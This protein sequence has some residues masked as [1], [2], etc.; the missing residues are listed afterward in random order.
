MAGAADKVPDKAPATA[1]QQQV[2]PLSS[3][4]LD[5]VMASG[6]GGSGGG[7]QA[8]GGGNGP[9]QVGGPIVLAKGSAATF[10]LRVRKGKAQIFMADTAQAVFWNGTAL[11]NQS[12]VQLES[13]GWSD[14]GDVDKNT[15]TRYYLN[16]HLKM[17]WTRTLEKHSVKETIDGEE[18]TVERL[19]VAD[20]FEAFDSKEYKVTE[21]QSPSQAKD[22]W[23]AKEAT[24]GGGL[25]ASPF[26]RWRRLAAMKHEENETA[27]LEAEVNH[28]V[29]L[30]GI[31]RGQARNNFIG[32]IQFVNF[33][34]TESYK[35]EDDSGDGT[36]SGTS[37]SETTET[38]GTSGTSDET[39]GETTGGQTTGGHTTGGGT[40]TPPGPGGETTGGGTGDEG[41]EFEFVGDIRYVCPNLQKRVDKYDPKTKKIT[42]GQW[43]TISGGTAVP[44]SGEH[45]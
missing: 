28:T 44:H 26:V 3:F 41:D 22:D 23:E 43:V 5:A 7:A 10:Q 4:Y 40:T 31:Y 19:F 21:S 24:G 33:T 25:A 42:I 14:L 1:P 35:P 12:D 13:G 45:A 36:G 39:S 6:G 29:L 38:T 20:R 37:G 11:E 15:D 17:R 9:V 30:G 32:A 34:G 2:Q 27:T 8:V 18:K 16:I